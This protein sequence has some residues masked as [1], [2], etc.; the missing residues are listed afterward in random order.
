M[1]NGNFGKIIRK[2]ALNTLSV[3]L[4]AT[5][6]AIQEAIKEMSSPKTGGA[7]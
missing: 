3:L 6:T 7:Q 4:H 5:E 1:N 2:A